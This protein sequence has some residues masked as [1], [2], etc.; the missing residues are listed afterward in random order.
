MRGLRV[1]R[2]KWRHERAYP[3][4]HGHAR[5]APP[6]DVAGGSCARRIVG[7]RG[8]DDEVR[9]G[10]GDGQAWR[11]VLPRGTVA[12]WCTHTGARPGCAPRASPPPP[13]LRAEACRWP[14]QGRC[15]GGL[16]GCV[17]ACVFPVT[18]PAGACA[19]RPN[20][21]VW[22]MLPHPHHPACKAAQRC[23]TSPAAH[24]HARLEATRERAS[25]AEGRRRPSPPPPPLRGQPPARYTP[26]GSASLAEQRGGRV[27]VQPA[28]AAWAARAAWQSDQDLNTARGTAVHGTAAS[29]RL[30]AV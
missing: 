7:I 5:I 15:C 28:S 21:C 30:M 13:S 25:A 16:S 11:P 9:R 8:G 3:C 24:L 10:C 17:R 23:P 2:S 1:Q 20:S 19:L 29:A 22:E 14:P 12:R 6:V 27:R 4:R 18:S 26:Q